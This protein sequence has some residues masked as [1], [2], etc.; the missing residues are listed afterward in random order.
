VG[1]IFDPQGNELI[2]SDSRTFHIKQINIDNPRN[3]GPTVRPKPQ[4]KGGG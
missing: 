1:V 4:P 2:R 3:A